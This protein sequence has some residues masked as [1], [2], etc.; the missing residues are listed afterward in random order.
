M[1]VATQIVVKDVLLCVRDGQV[2]A[3]RAE[4]PSLAWDRVFLV[5]I[6]A[7]LLAACGAIG[8]PSP[9]PNAQP[10][11]AA[12]TNPT[13]TASTITAATELPRSPSPTPIIQPAPKPT[14]VPVP[15][16]PTGVKFGEQRRLGNDPSSTEIT[17]TVRWQAPQSESVE[18]R[19]YGVTKCIAEPANPSPDTSGPCLVEHTPLPGSVLTLLATAPASKGHVSWTWTGTFDCEGPGPAY[20]PRGPAYHAVV[21]AAYSASGHS[22]FAIAEPGRWSQPGPGETVC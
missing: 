16:K 11:E 20:D 6:L 4:G 5:A 1:A 19:V 18:I 3:E 2:T 9:V 22:I 7:A 8:A 17:Q 21:I 12:A 13:A 14:P 10:T 15:P